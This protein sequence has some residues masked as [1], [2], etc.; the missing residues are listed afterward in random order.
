MSELQQRKRVIPNSELAKHNTSN[1]CWMAIYGKVYDVTAFLED[2]PGGADVM[3]D[4]AGKDATEEFDAIGHTESA[5]ALLPK[6]YVG[7]AEVDTSRPVKKPAAAA[8]SGGGGG[9]SGIKMMIAIAV[10]GLVAYLWH[11]TQAGHAVAS[12]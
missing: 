9:S 7:E 1:D 3:L 11:T 2:H 6:Y 10:L 8:A 12:S 4:Q 5:K